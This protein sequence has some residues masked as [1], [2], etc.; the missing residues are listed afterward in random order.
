MRAE[1][2]C[3]CEG[4]FG[5]RCRDAVTVVHA[6]RGKTADREGNTMS[7]KNGDKARF[8]KERRKKVLRRQRTRALLKLHGAKPMAKV[9]AGA[10][11]TGIAPQLPDTE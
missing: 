11:T 1:G 5:Q 7:E 6:G 8:G 10:V 9:N 3:N 4:R 2:D